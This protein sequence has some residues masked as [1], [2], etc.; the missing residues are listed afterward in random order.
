MHPS[1]YI[2]LSQLGSGLESGLLMY[3]PNVRRQ[4]GH[5]LGAFFGRMFRHLLPFAKNVIL[6]SAIGAVRNIAS[7]RLEG[8]NLKESLKSN[9]IGVLKDVG[10]NLLGQ[11]GSGRRRGRKRKRSSKPK[12]K[13]VKKRKITKRRKPAKRRRVKKSLKK[14]DFVSLFD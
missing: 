11:T 5:G 13:N 8:K 12:N 1:E 9:A 14:S 3:R 10:S 4:H 6:P 7:D 2:V